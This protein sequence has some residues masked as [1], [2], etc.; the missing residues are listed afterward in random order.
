MRPDIKPP[1]TSAGGGQRY[2]SNERNIENLISNV[3][4][5]ASTNKRRRFQP[6]SIQQSKVGR[7][8]L[9]SDAIGLP[10]INDNLSPTF[11]TA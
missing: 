3:Y 2:L 4:G 9:I 5:T 10:T 8:E 11:K 1:G 6:L 7:E